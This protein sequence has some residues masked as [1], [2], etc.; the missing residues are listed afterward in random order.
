VRAIDDIA[1][2][3]RE[4]KDRIG[5]KPLWLPASEWALNAY[6]MQDEEWPGCLCYG[7]IVE[8]VDAE[9][10]EILARDEFGD[11]WFFPARC[12]MPLVPFAAELL[13][14]LR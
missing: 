6:V 3:V 13:E 10:G 5:E 8:I 4:T 7:A 14:A 2:A 9:G 1:R 12:L 11:E